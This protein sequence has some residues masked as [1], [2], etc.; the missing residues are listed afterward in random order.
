LSLDYWREGR[1][2]SPESREAMVLARLSPRGE[3]GRVA[4]AVVRRGG[5]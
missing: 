4:E 5:A 1:E 2:S 3:G